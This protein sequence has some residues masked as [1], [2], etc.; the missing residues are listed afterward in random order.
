MKR[1]ELEIEED[2]AETLAATM[3][4]RMRHHRGRR[5][6]AM[7]LKHVFRQIELRVTDASVAGIRGSGLRCRDVFLLGVGEAPNFVHLNALGL[8]VAHVGVGAGQARHG[9]DVFG[10][11]REGEGCGRAV[12]SCPVMMEI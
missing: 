12:P 5:V 4:D 2:V 1:L 11:R 6:D 10:L 9:G 8:H 3:S 7:K